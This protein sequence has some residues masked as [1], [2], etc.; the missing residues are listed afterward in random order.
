M[1]DGKLRAQSLGARRANTQ[2]EQIE[3]ANRHHVTLA[4]RFNGDGVLPANLGAY[5]GTT[6]DFCARLWPS[7]WLGSQAYSLIN[8]HQPFP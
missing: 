6:A 7:E 8:R 3:H 2:L 1:P 5:T 4:K